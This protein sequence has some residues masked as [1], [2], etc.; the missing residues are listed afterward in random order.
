MQFGCYFCCFVR[1][2]LF[3]NRCTNWRNF[4]MCKY[5]IVYSNNSLT[6]FAFFLF[7]KVVFYF[8]QKWLLCITFQYF[9]KS[10]RITKLIDL[11]ELCFP[12]RPTLIESWSPFF[13]YSIVENEG[14]VIKLKRSESLRLLFWPATNFFCLIPVK[15]EV[16][17]FS[18]AE[19]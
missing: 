17:T 7:W 2:K 18:T 4:H 11:T 13:K 9:H 19:K 8:Q 10:W 15:A 6:F 5:K 3:K 1:Y 12:F 14:D 16:N